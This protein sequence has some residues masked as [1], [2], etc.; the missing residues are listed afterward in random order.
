VETLALGLLCTLQQRLMFTAAC[1]KSAVSICYLA[2]K[3]I[4]LLVA[5]T[6]CHVVLDAY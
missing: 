6:R 4:C 1:P 3:L 5:L 2:D